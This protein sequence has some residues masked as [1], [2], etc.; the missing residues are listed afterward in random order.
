VYLAALDTLSSLGE[1]VLKLLDLLEALA[2]LLGRIGELEAGVVELDR[3]LELTV[4]PQGVASLR[5]KIN[6]HFIKNGTRY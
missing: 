4:A 6:I 5:L 2:A 1:V 3:A